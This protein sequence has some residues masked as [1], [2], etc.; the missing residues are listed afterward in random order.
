MNSI[1]ALNRLLPTNTPNEDRL[2]YF[3]VV[4][5]DLSLFEE[6]KKDN[7]LVNLIK[8]EICTMQDAYCENT[9]EEKEIN[10]YIKRLRKIK[11][12]LEEE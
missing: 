1:K 8:K 7:L 3:N 5:K 12:R 4:K 9:G 11:E 6:L 10:A 2:E